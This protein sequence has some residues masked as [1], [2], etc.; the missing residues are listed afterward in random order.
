MTENTAYIDNMP[1]RINGGETILDFVRRNLGREII[2][3]LCQS[4]NLENYGS[5]RV[6]SV[7]V[8]LMEG[9]PARIMASCH[10]PVASGYYIYPSTERIRR[11]RRNILELV[12][13]EY[14]PGRLC[15]ESGMLPTEFQ[16]VVATHGS[17]D[18]TIQS[19]FEKS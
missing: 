13:S 17:S 9:G 7:E 19:L 8:A 4:D 15:P 1:F 12:L 10:T 16:S 5:C 14:P 6:C 11:L 2:P 18:S 3:T